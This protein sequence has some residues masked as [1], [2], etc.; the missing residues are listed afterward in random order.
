MVDGRTDLTPIQ[1]CRVLVEIAIR[2]HKGYNDI[3]V[4]YQDQW[5]ENLLASF[6][7]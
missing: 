1:Y 2:R 3:N 6:K 5:A 4:I 7:A